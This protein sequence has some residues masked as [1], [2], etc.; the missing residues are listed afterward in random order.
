MDRTEIINRIFD[1]RQTR[2]QH[3]AGETDNS[4][5]YPSDMERCVCCGAVRSPSR[6]YP[7]SLMLHCRTRVH[8]AALVD[9]HGATSKKMLALAIGENREARA[10]VPQH[11]ACPD[12][13]AYKSVAIRADGSYVSIYDGTSWVIG[14][15]RRQVPRR[16]HNGGY[17][18]HETEAG[19][20][21]ATLPAD[22]I[23]AWSPRAVLQ[24]RV[25][26]RYCRY[27]GGKLAFER[28]TPVGVAIRS[29]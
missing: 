20:E 21:Y 23:Y 14:V 25:A 17:Y 15:E 29:V 5:W 28:V 13:I 24:C 4:R 22:A 6:A 7:W 2:R 3:P 11:R 8:I 12:G 16:G 9:R 18:V 27:D 19:A 26:G 1:A 10:A